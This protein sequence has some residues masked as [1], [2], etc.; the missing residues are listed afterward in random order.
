MIISFLYPLTHPSILL[1]ETLEFKKKKKEI[2]SP[3][4][5]TLFMEYYH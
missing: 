4:L 5:I 1:N 2:S 3:I